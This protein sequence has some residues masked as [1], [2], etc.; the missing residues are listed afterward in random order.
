MMADGRVTGPFAVSEPG[1]GGH[2][3]LIQTRAERTIDGSFS[4]TGEK[5]TTNG[6]ISDFYVV[7]AVSGEESNGKKE[8]I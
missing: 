1:R 3:K 7:I 8:I 4:I 5:P 2:P 6:P